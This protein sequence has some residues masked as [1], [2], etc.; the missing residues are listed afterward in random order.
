M[1]QIIT[2]LLLATAM[3]AQGAQQTTQSNVYATAHGKKYHTHKECQY[4]KGRDIQT[5][6]LD[7]AKAK[8]LTKC[9][10]CENKDNEAKKEVKK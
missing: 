5:I 2:T 10:R 3:V 7:K 1:K 4:I 9:A 6:T 8:D